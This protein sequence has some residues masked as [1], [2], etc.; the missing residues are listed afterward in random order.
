MA[1]V[2]RDAI[3]GGRVTI[4]QPVK[5]YRVNADA[6][7]LAAFA[8]RRIGAPAASGS[9]PRAASAMFDLGAGVGAVALTALALGAARTAAL[10]EVDATYAALA[11]QNLRANGHEGNACVLHEDALSAAARHVGEA[12]LVVCN[13]PYVPPGRGR[14]PAPERARARAGPVEVFLD[15]TRKLL[16]RRGRACFVYPA[17]EATTLLAALRARGLEPKRVASVHGREGAPARVLLVEAVPGRPGGL[18][19]APP[20]VETD[21]RGSPTVELVALMRGA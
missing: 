1:E 12:D 18:V 20:I 17:I 5:G 3:L 8:A 9:P 16:G 21:A 11:E 4:A 7:L 15:A 14:A 2:T 6:V 13:P 19:V 10:V